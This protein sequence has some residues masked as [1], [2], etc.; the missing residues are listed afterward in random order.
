M[1]EFTSSGNPEDDRRTLGWLQRCLATDPEAGVL[2]SIVSSEDDGDLIQVAP[3]SRV[4]N[5]GPLSLL[6]VIRDLVLHLRSRM[7]FPA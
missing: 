7:S 4:T 2:V 6:F 1:P 5:M 3:H